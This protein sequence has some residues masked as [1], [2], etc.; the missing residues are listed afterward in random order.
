VVRY[1]TV[2]YCTVRYG[3]VVYGTVR[4]CTVR[5]DTRHWCNFEAVTVLV[6]LL[7][8]KFIALYLLP[9]LRLFDVECC[10]MECNVTFR[11]I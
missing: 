2:R 7:A 3:T 8:C 10:I 5:Y 4:Y 9:H 1:G 6:I 11:I